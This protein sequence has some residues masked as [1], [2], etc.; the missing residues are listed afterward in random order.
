MRHIESKSINIWLRYDPKCNPTS[1]PHSLQ[2]V[3]LYFGSYLSQMWMD[4]DSIWLILKLTVPFEYND[5]DIRMS[6]YPFTGKT[7]RM[8]EYLSH[9]LEALATTGGK[10]EDTSLA[11]HSG[12]VFRNCLA[13][14][15]RMTL[16]T[17]NSIM[18][19]K[20]TQIIRLHFCAGKINHLCHHSLFVISQAWKVWRTSGTILNELRKRMRFPLCY[21]SEA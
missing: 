1:C 16:S 9:S 6:G 3:R 14:I 7:I 5:C 19:S 11:L 13:S 17:M 4:F 8:C 21:L 15:S 18:R 10:R 20:V 2:M 12:P